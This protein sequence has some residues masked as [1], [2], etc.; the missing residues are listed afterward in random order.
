MNQKFNFIENQSEQISNIKDYIYRILSSWKWFL[1]SLILALAISYYYNISSEKVY[2][3]KTIIAVKEKQNPLFA[4]GTNIAFNWGGVSDKVE[5]IRKQ[6]TSRT[7]TEKVIRRLHFYIDYL[8][9]GKF[10]K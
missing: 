10:R 6:L 4:S 5:S 9:E 1:A 3:L 2:G 8:K 7:H